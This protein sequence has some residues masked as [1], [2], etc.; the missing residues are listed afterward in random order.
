MSNTYAIVFKGE[1]LDGADEAAV[2]QKVGAMFKADA[3]KIAALF[4]GKPVAIKK[5]VDEATANKFVAAFAKAGAKAYAKDMAAPAEPAPPAAQT[6]TITA[7]PPPPAEPVAQ[8][9]AT[10]TAPA[11]DAGSP[12]ATTASVTPTNP[13]DPVQISAASAAAVRE[14]PQTMVNIQ[15]Q[16]SLD[17]LSMSAEGS[18]LVEAT[19]EDYTPAPIAIEAD[20]ADEGT[21]I[22]APARDTTPPPEP[23]DWSVS[24][25]AGAPSGKAT[26][27]LDP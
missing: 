11:A 9:A 13:D 18:L 24:D 22:P 21:S 17:D 16:G 12:P 27:S 25:G 15:P 20:L 23:G 2:Q 5:N 26:F 6:E 7:A 10:Q 4:S 1:I 14:A 3:A 8:P 19:P